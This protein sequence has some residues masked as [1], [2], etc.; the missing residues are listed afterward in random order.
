MHK[1][2]MKNKKRLENC[3]GYLNLKTSQN[4]KDRNNGFPV[5]LRNKT[6]KHLSFVKTL[7]CLNTIS[8]EISHFI[9]KRLQHMCF[10]CD[11][12]SHPEVFNKI[13]FLKDYVKFTEEAMARRY[14]LKW[15]LFKI[16]QNSVESTTSLQ[17]LTTASSLN[18]A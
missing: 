18:F 1:Y 16:P 10:F 12:S 15:M 17:L 7:R 14:Y 9:G 8:L 5:W 6:W 4:M 3:L 11:T 2:N 13:S